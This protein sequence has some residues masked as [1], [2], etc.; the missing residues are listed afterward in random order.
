M[1]TVR[2]YESFAPID[3]KHGNF[4]LI[5]DPGETPR[6]VSGPWDWDA[7]K[8]NVVEGGRLAYGELEPHFLPEMED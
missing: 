7:G 3:I 4:Y 2:R 6:F 8:V 5:A 1:P